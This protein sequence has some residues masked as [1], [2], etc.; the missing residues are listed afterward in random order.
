MAAN[1]NIVFHLS[2]GNP[3]NDSVGIGLDKRVFGKSLGGKLFRKEVL[4]NKELIYHQLL[5]GTLELF[6]AIV[7]TDVIKSKVNYRAIFITNY[8]IDHVILDTITVSNII[9]DIAFGQ[10]LTE[11]D[12]AVEGIYTTAE[13]SRPIPNTRG[14]AGNPSIYLDD[15][16]DSTGKLAGMTWKKTLDATDLPTDIPYDACLKIWVRRRTVLDK[17]TMPDYEVQEGFTLTVNEY[18]GE[19]STP[20]TFNHK[21]I[22]GRVP[23][24]NWYDFTVTPG[25]GKPVVMREF[26]PKDVDLTEINVLKVFVKEDKVLIFYYTQPDAAT[27][28][29]ML[30]AVEPNDIPAKNK[31]VQVML[32]FDESLEDDERFTSR[33]Q[34]DVHRS[35]YDL[36]KFFIFWQDEV[37]IDITCKPQFF[38]LVDNYSRIA[39]DS[40]DTHLWTGNIF[41]GINEGY[42]NRKIETY[43]LLDHKVVR[44][45]ARLVNVEHFDDLFILFSVDTKNTGLLNLENINLN[46]NQLLYLFEKDIID[47]KRY[48]SVK[49]FPGESAEVFSQRLYPNSLPKNKQN[50]S[51]NN[52]KNSQI[53]VIVSNSS[54]LDTDTS[55]PRTIKSL[56]DGTRYVDLN[57]AHA[58]EFKIG[59][60]FVTYDLP[61]DNQEFNNL[62]L[63]TSF[64]VANDENIYA[65]KKSSYLTNY[66]MNNVVGSTIYERPL[67]QQN[68]IDQ[69][70]MSSLSIPLE[71]ADRRYKDEWKTIFS[72][73]PNA[74]NDNSPSFKLE[75]NFYRNIWQATYFDK[76]G[77]ETS[78]I[79]D[80]LVGQEQVITKTNTTGTTAT[81]AMPNI[82][83]LFTELDVRDMPFVL[84]PDTYQPLSVRIVTQSVIATENE[85]KYMVNY[86]VYFKGNETPLID[87]VTVVTAINDLSYVFINPE[88]D[89]S[90]RL[91][92]LDVQS[93]NDVAKE[94]YVKN[95]HAAL[96]NKLIVKFGKEFEVNPQLFQEQ[97][98]FTHYR[99]L[100]ITGIGLPT[101]GFEQNG[102]ITIP[103]I[104]YGNGYKNDATNPYSLHLGV[105]HPFDFSKV[106]IND[107]SMRFYY[108][109]NNRSPI[110]FK[111]SYYDYDKDY[112][113]IWLRVQDFETSNK[114][115]YMFYGKSTTTERYK[116]VQESYIF[117]KNML[118][119]KNVFGAWHFDNIISDDR[120]AFN[121]GKILKMGEP[122]IYEK[123]FDEE[124]HLTRIDKEYMYGIAKIYK[125]HYFNINMDIPAEE[126]LFL[127]PKLKDEF[128]GFVKSVAKVFKPSYTE[129]NAVKQAG[130]DV[131][132]AGEVPMGDTTN[133]RVAGLVALAPNSNVNTYYDRTD[134]TRFK[135]LTSFNGYT[136]KIDFVVAR[137]IDTPI[138]KAGVL[139]VNGKV[140]SETIKFE[141]PFK[142]KDYFVFVASPVNQK[143]YWNLLCES[144]F[145][146]TASH[147]LMKEVAWMAFHKDIYGGVYTPN[148]I[149]VGKRTLTGSTET[150]GG[151]SPT[152]ANGSTWYNN[153]LLIKPDI[154]VQGD[155]GTM[156]IDPTDPGYSLILSSNE[157]INIYWT[158]KQSN[159]FRVKTSSPVA[160]TVHWLVVR[161]GIEWWQELV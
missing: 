111:V 35:F 129:I 89:L 133:R 50:T 153:E 62:F 23:L 61:P 12:I 18:N 160:C 120:L 110:P 9:P 39:V 112:A 139:R 124:I 43:K 150:V 26:L 20:I 4:A 121:E 119:S 69:G 40:I 31:Y 63:T 94:Y 83:K 44:K 102:D 82:G 74:I 59:E 57:S 142:D 54:T 47:S 136:N 114:K 42:S 107:R 154:A 49:H 130:I 14:K 91:N 85:Q 137:P 45:F 106:A 55:S 75:Y 68:I 86:Q 156:L 34:I 152:V 27:K 108:E 33:K 38:G 95:L 41:A 13:V 122:I 138:F 56:L 147:Y 53:N 22:A 51:F 76:D 77:V 105:E 98:E 93:G 32:E 157:N 65:E 81:S 73:L 78:K 16:Y 151:E 123:T 80:H 126:D 125:S 115:I 158:E 1:E 60:N 48:T 134:E 71:W 132:E 143:V 8:S 140:K 5:N 36:D 141:T 96:M 118:Y 113:V 6:D 161:N 28:N 46:R 109:G 21:K 19:A 79:Y 37:A 15:E 3:N 67:F 103:V 148:S 10:A 70:K 90:V 87:I 72:T 128:V 25:K 66:S 116:E 146:I 84:E 92:Y 104:L 30:L 52:V 99:H 2:R 24:A 88:K 17:L 101:T 100:K 97:A 144:R 117:L 131:L 64:A 29:Y 155:P 127:N 11:V 149:Y 135:A 145:T 7:P 159:Q 58:R